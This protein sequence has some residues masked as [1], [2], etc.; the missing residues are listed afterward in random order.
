MTNKLSALL[1]K[2]N[3]EKQHNQTMNFLIDFLIGGIAGAVAKTL[4]APFNRSKMVLQNQD[5]NPRIRSGEV[6][7]YDGTLDVITRLIEEQGAESLWDGNLLNIL[8]YFPTQAMNFALKDSYKNLLPKYDPRSDFGKFFLV[9]IATGGLAGANTL[10]ITH[11]LNYVRRRLESELGT[12]KDFRG[13]IDVVV[14]TINGPNGIAGLYQGFSI[15][16]LGI[17]LYRG[18]YFGLYDTFAASNPYRQHQGWKS[19]LSRFIVAQVVA[20]TAGFV[21]YPIDTI[22]NRLQMQADKP[23]SEWL[24]NGYTDCV[25]KIAKEEG[26]Q[27]FFKGAGANIL[28]TIVASLVLV[29]YDV[30]LDYFKRDQEQA[31]VDNM[32][33]VPRPQNKRQK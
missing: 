22:S 10:L 5:A 20:I 14:K 28:R 6:Q 25:S 30:V 13:A 15:N 17:I 3:F 29:G 12:T 32:A 11:P 27:G 24:Y 21:T 4:T 31:P 23:Q 33:V 19:T 16:I 2:Q 26:V 8:Q 1:V 7:R 18:A 9:N